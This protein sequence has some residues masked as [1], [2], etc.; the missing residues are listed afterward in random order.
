[1]YERD[2]REMIPLQQFLAQSKTGSLSFPFHAPSS[3]T[4]TD[5]I[6]HN[7]PGIDMS[8]NRASVWSS[9]SERLKSAWLPT[10]EL[11]KTNRGESSPH[12]K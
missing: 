10:D 5:V 4:R 7:G 1:M 3:S 8:F 12:L 11:Q 2:S 6:S 9:Q